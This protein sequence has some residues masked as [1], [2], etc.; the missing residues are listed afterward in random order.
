MKE[1][2]NM[3][4]S[5]LTQCDFFPPFSSWTFF[6]SQF[7]QT[8]NKTIS[9]YGNPSPG[10]IQTPPSLLYFSS[11]LVLCSW[12]QERGSQVYF[13]HGGPFRVAERPL[14]RHCWCI[15]WGSTKRSQWDSFITTPLNLIV[16]VRGYLV[17]SFSRG[18]SERVSECDWS[19]P[20]V[21]LR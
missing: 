8:S 21:V 16:S 5:A 1:M 18:Q 19:Q 15:R 4:G 13:H 11:S 20:M 7:G 14:P 17:L 3:M 2:G 12:P 6:T 10:N 9:K